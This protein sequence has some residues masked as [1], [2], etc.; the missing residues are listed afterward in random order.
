MQP[1]NY[2]SY[3]GLYR[4]E[5]GKLLRQKGAA[6]KPFGDQQNY[7]GESEDQG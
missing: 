7:L 5:V 6:P 1:L 4:E 2:L 3:L